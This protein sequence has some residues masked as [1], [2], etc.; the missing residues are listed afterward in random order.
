MR[1]PADIQKA[2]KNLKKLA[3][4]HR[5][6]KAKALDPEVMMTHHRLMVQYEKEIEILNWVLS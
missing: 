6:L 4:N 3:D 1:S 5:D 2:I